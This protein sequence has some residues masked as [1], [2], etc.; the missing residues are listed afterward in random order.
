MQR[1]RIVSRTIQYGGQAYGAE[2]RND[3]KAHHD[4]RRANHEIRGLL[5]AD[6]YCG[7]AVGGRLRHA[8]MGHCLAP[9]R[10]AYLAQCSE[11]E[12]PVDSG[13]EPKT[14]EGVRVV[15]LSKER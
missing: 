11:A 4:S 10:T 1:K 15:Y 8:V 12:R 6:S 5:Q 2:C 9:E 3:T 13:K 14:C 7:H